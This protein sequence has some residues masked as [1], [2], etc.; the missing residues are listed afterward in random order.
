[1]ATFVEIINDPQVLDS[2]RYLAAG[3]AMGLAAIGPG[4]GEGYAAGRAVVGIAR[5]P[6]QAGSLLKNMLIGQAIAETSGI[7]GLVIAIILVA[8]GQGNVTDWGVGAALIGSGLAV[9]MSAIGPGIGAGLAAGKALD[10]IGRT[11]QA[12]SKVTLTM[13]IGQALS[14]NAAILGFLISIMLMGV[15]REAL[16]VGD[17]GYWPS[18]IVKVGKYLGAG[19][20]MGMGAVGPAIGI[21][22]AAAKAVEGVGR[23]LE[24]AGL[25]QRTMFVGVAVSESTA[26]YALVISLLLMMQ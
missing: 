19:V 13:L 10:S 24:Q 25:L 1:M 20:C 26:I 15:A 8:R 11:P 23:R 12:T 22:F 17:P 16:D 4:V 5:Q 9:G 3:L 21:G 2:S 7:L 18:I 6:G 14:Q